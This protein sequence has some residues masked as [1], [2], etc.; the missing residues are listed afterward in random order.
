MAFYGEDIVV[1]STVRWR[2]KILRDCGRNVDL[3]DQPHSGR[4][5]IATHYVNG[6]KLTTI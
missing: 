2:V 1:I 3:N 6:L 5:V 4:P